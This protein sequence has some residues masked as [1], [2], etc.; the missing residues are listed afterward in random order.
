MRSAR[1]FL[2]TSLLLTGIAAA[3]VSDTN[4]AD[5]SD[6]PSTFLP[7]AK[8]LN[9][10][11]H[12]TPRGFRPNPDPRNLTSSYIQG[13]GGGPPG[14]P[15]GAPPGGGPPGA[16]PPPP[17]GGPDSPKAPN[18]CIPSFDFGAEGI[19][20]VSEPQQITIISEENHQ[21]R[22]IYLDSV[23]A[24]DARPSYSGESIGHWQGKTLVVDTIAIKGRPGAHLLERWSKLP[25]GSISIRSVNLGPDDKPLGPPEKTLLIWRPDLRFVEDICEDYGEAFGANYGK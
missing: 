5:V 3:Q 25:N 4:P 9:F 23:H 15:G 8:T 20:I 6:V 10:A 22:R 13:G 18:R 1:L 2:G 12:G 24:P 16:G 17:G 7:N 14:P 19:H 11:P 21:I